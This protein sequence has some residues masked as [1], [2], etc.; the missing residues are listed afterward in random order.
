MIRTLLILWLAPLSFFW[1]WYFLSLND[2]NF[3]TIFFSRALHDEVFLIYGHI[4]GVD[5]QAIPGMAA[6]AI[7]VDSIF[8]AGLIAFRKRRAIKAFYDRR[9]AAS[10]EAAAEIRSE[11]SLSSAP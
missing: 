11:E 2:I 9:K 7:G 6:K 1:S 3:G 5:P 10:A 4:L 8:L